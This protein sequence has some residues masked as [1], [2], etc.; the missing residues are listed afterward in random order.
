M[1][2]GCSQVSGCDF[3]ETLSP[4]VKPTNIQTILLIVVSKKRPL[5]QVDVN[6]VFLNG[7][8]FEEVYMQQPHGYMKF[9]I[10]GQ[11]L[12]FRLTKALYGLRQASR[13]WFDK[14]RSFL[15]SIGFVRAWSD[16]SLFVRR[17]GTSC[18]YVLVYVNDIIITGDSS[19]DIDSFVT[20]VTF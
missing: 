9:G 13:A 19:S 18:M 3:Q 20:S 5:Q 11:P 8:L 6:N 12:V 17:S 1:A 14:L 15:V 10:D 16:T 2:K 7:D 4:V